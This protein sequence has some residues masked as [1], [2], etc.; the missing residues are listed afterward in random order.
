MSSKKDHE[1]V[2]ASRQGDKESFGLL[3]DRYQP[4]TTSVIQ[5]MVADELFHH[6]LFQE[7]ILSAY[8]SLD[9]LHDSQKFRSWLY[10][11]T[12]N[13]CLMFLRL[14]RVQSISL[15]FLEETGGGLPSQ[16]PSPDE[17]AERLELRRAMLN[18]ISQLSVTNRETILLFYYEDFD[19]QETATLLGISVNTAKGRLHRARKHLQQL[20]TS[21]DRSQEGEKQMIPVKVVDVVMRDYVLSPNKSRKQYQ[22]VLMDEAQRRAIII[23]IGEYEGLAIAFKLNNVDLIGRPMT[24]TFIARLIDASGA[25]LERVEINELKDDVFYATVHLN[26]NGELRQV[27]ARP[28]DAIGLAMNTDTPLFVSEQVVEQVGFNIPDKHRPNKQGIAEIQAWL[29]EL[30]ESDSTHLEGI[31]ATEEYQQLFD[32]QKQGAIVIG[33]IFEP[34]ES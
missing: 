8:L 28:S 32:H 22:L 18:T 33:K 2:E 1:L 25:S 29:D 3:I 31:K 19:L 4:M 6:D 20:L 17:I 23:W 9:T 7:T 13:V 27:D 5:R 34:I 14:Q 10:G 12:R 21:L 30:K 24:Q 26:I 11:I 16:Q 15:D